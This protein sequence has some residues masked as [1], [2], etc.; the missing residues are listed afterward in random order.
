MDL[1][2]SEIVCDLCLVSPGLLIAGFCAGLILW[3][4]GWWSHRFW[5][6]LTATVLGGIWGLSHAAALNAQPLA[7]ALLVALAAGLLGLALVRVLAYLAG[8]VFGMLLVHAVYPNF[9]QPVV[10]FL[11][12]GLVCICLFR[13]GMMVLTSFLGSLLMGYCGLAIMH[14]QGT[15]DAI[16][17]SSQGASMFSW[18]CGLL[19]VLGFLVQLVMERRRRGAVKLV[20]K[21]KEGKTRKKDDD[22]HGILGRVFRKAG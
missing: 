14:H 17:W 4:L 16:T 10:T 19:T 20:P 5:V 22:A 13:I 11:V 6:V 7:T 21:E 2:V 15:L 1:M 8:G 12:S 9:Q 18:V 3:M